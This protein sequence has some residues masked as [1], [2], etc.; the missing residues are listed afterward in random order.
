MTPR[1]SSEEKLAT[2]MT[3][4]D[5]CATKAARLFACDIS[6]MRKPPDKLGRHSMT[7][8]VSKARAG[9]IWLLYRGGFSLTEISSYF[10]SAQAPL[11]QA[12]QRFE[13]SWIPSSKTNRAKLDLL[14][15]ET[16]G[17]LSNVFKI[18]TKAVKGR[19]GP[20]WLR[21]YSTLTEF[22]GRLE[23]LEAKVDKL[24]SE[25]EWLKKTL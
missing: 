8:E 10:N 14:I 11:Y 20:R 2:I 4:L 9:V 7:V 24:V 1:Y 12:Y 19:R 22:S 18:E 21:N 5:K 3:I 13:N 23:A 15:Q 6:V 16:Q 17:I 25:F